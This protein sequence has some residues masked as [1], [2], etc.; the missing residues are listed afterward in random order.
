[1]HLARNQSATGPKKDS[2]HKE[3][4]PHHF[5]FEPPN[6]PTSK[7]TCKIPGC[8]AKQELSNS[9]YESPWKKGRRRA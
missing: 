1:M 8:S 7:G 5:I 9:T 4:H 6:G 3:G 2:G